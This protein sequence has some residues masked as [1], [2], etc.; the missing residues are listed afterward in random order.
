[1]KTPVTTDR[2]LHEIMQARARVYRLAQATPIQRLEL[3][4]TK[5]LYL[6][7][8][9]L[10]PVHSYKWRGAFNMMATLSAEE[11]ARGVATASA[12]NHAQG[13]A[14]SA[15]HLGC[16]ARI[17]MPKSTPRMKVREVERLG[18][19]NVDIVLDGDTYDEVSEFAKAFALTSN[20]TYIPPY[21]NL[22][23]MAGQGTIGDEIVMSAIEPEVVFLQIGGGG[24]AAATAC[25]LKSYYPHVRIIGVEGEGQASMKRAVEAGKP[26]LL[27]DLDVFCDGTAV[28]IAGE[29]TFP[30]C[31]SLIDE[32]MT[33]SNDEVCA[34]IE[35]LW[36]SARLISEPAGAMGIAAAMKRRADIAG[37]R[38]VCILSGANMDFVKLAWIARHARVGLAERR[39]FEFEIGEDKGSLLSLL[40]TVM[41]GVNIVDFQYGK[42]HE[43][44]ARP[45]IGLEASSI[46]LEMLDRRMRE[47]NVVHRDVTSREDVEFRMIHFHSHLLRNPH[48]TIIEFP[49]RPGAL[50][51]FLR[52]IQSRAD[53]CYFNYE[54][55]GEEVGRAM[56][57]FCLET[58]EDAAAFPAFLTSHGIH[59]REIS[60]ALLQSFFQ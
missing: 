12:G 8:E 7:R 36:E 32:F 16:R 30:L 27:D 17:F 9:D 14:L 35:L 50:L 47:N 25:L 59:H 38:T 39:Y 6:K 10:T 2:L 52:H 28:K 1:M 43:K 29:L 11:R 42:V 49:E 4:F 31:R 51:E 37:K 58:P 24:M 46:L 45:V 33:V 40:E 60:P 34:G 18:G 55:S 54:I 13:V 44:V 48:F 26:T 15:S 20:A 5:D 19:T 3:P 22:L 41:E 53:I 23:V 21:D 56:M 57:G